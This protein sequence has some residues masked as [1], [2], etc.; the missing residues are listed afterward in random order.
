M[1]N[2]GVNNVPDKTIAIFLNEREDFTIDRLNNVIERPDK[3]R[4]WFANNFYR[5]LPLVIGNTQGF[6]IK[7][8]FSFSVLWTGENSNKSLG[9]QTDLTDNKN[10]DGKNMYPEISSHFGHGILTIQ[11]PFSIRT[12]IGVNI[13]TMNPPNFIVP[14]ATVMTGVVETDN[15]RR[16][17]TFN[18]KIQIPNIKVSFPAGTPLA[19]F[20]PIPRY[21]CDAFQL[22][23]AEDIFSEDVVKKEQKAATDAYDFRD[24]VEPTLPH[25]VGKHYFK[26]VDVYGNKFTDHQIHSLSNKV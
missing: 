25:Q 14:N 1:I 19:A 20:I 2:D 21:F 17:F 5:C 8:E 4:N 7:S 16:D 22:A 15:L 10:H 26:G 18:I 9:I 13:L 24:N 23:N 6:V 12:P 3:K 11:T